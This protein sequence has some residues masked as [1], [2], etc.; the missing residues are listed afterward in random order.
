MII[1]IDKIKRG[2]EAIL[3]GKKAEDLF[4]YCNIK[5]DLQ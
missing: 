4:N 5:D 3:G 1:R 2:V